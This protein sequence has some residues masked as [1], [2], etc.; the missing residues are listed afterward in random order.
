M[1]FQA[2]HLQR[3]SGSKKNL[4]RDLSLRFSILL[5]FLKKAF[6]FKKFRPK[7]SQKTKSNLKTNL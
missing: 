1:T 6:D 2:N 5:S 7:Q 4:N 3:L